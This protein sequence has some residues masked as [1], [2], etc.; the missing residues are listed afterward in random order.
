MSYHYGTKL[1]I[2]L[3]G[4]SHQEAVGAVIEGLPA[5]GLYPKELVNRE[6]RK[7]APGQ[8]GTTTRVEQDEPKILCGLLEGRYTGSA[9]SVIFK[10][11]NHKSKDYPLMYRPSHSDYPAQL[12]YQGYQDRRGGGQFSGRLTLPLVFAGALCQSLLEA[13]GIEIHT[14]LTQVGA[15]SFE[16]YTKFSSEELKVKDAIDE[17]VYEYLDDLGKDSVGARIECAIMHVPGGIGEP[18]FD[19]VESRL[20]H[21]LFS[22]PGLKG[23]LFGDA[24]MMSCL[25]GSEMNDCY[26]LEGKTLKTTSNHNGGILGGLSTGMPI[27]FECLFKPTPSIGL[28]QKTYDPL[29]KQMGTLEIRGRHDPCIGIRALPVVK[30]CAAIVIYDLLLERYGSDQKIRE[31][32]KK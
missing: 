12:R 24:L 25:K 16:R 20:S 28:A 8:R 5:G 27:V 10:N 11:Q 30:A 2:S 19:S 7:R 4:E 13:C 15:L 9:L 3:F 14:H 32:I 21:L 29:T 6:I 17:K 31:A 22:I 26:A 18:L 1:V 23:V